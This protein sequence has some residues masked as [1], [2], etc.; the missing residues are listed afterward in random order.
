MNKV[1]GDTLPQC[2][3]CARTTWE[4]LVRGDYKDRGERPTLFQTKKRVD[5]ATA[6]SGAYGSKW[7]D[8][9]FEN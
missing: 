1:G 8:T 5:G 9:I 4:A 2:I 7:P 3:G 6:Q